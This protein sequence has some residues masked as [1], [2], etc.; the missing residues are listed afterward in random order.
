[1]VNNYET[2]RD[3]YRPAAIK[4]LLIAESPPDINS[5]RFFYFEKYFSR[6]DSLF[7]ETMKALFPDNALTGG[8]YKRRKEE[9]LTKFMN[10]GLYLEDAS[11]IPFPKGSSKPF[12]R[13]KLQGQLP[14][15][16]EKL[17]TLIDH[18]IPIILISDTVFEICYDSLKKEG[19]NILNDKVIFFPISFQPQ[20]RS[21]LKA[22]VDKAGINLS[23]EE[24]NNK[25]DKELQAE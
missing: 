8:D 9:Y 13:K 3:K 2:A 7:M 24:L 16:K 25:P 11:S 22:N 5:E 23:P 17:L 15:L 6:G 14:T 10:A 20:Y 21:A 19:Y 12:K 1:M 4:C 18:S